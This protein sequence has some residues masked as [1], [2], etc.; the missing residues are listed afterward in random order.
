[1]SLAKII[2]DENDATTSIIPIETDLGKKK[3]I[4]NPIVS[5]PETTEVTE[6]D[7]GLIDL[8]SWF[9]KYHRQQKSFEPKIK[10]TNVQIV[11]VLTEERLVVSIIHPNGGTH[12][13]TK[14]PLRKM[15]TF[16]ACNTYNVMD[17]L[18]CDMD[19][20]SDNSC[21]IVHHLGE[22][23]YSKCYCVGTGLKVMHSTMVEGRL[24]PFTESKTNKKK[25]S[26]R[27][28]YCEPNVILRS[29]NKPLDKEALVLMYRQYQKVIDK[30]N[31]KIEAVIWLIDRSKTVMDINHQILIDRT[32]I[33]IIG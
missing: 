13:I 26:V 11:D 33:S 6:G 14:N 22:H 30:I 3:E 28:E 21:R 9:D 12:P 27:V 25:E 1:M 19:F 18:G 10:S 24:I 7:V 16:D 8:Y 17:L 2:Q 4:Q 29:L 20:Y 23:R 5:K 32:I 15:V 31:T